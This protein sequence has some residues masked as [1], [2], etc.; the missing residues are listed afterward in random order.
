MSRISQRRLTRMVVTMRVRLASESVILLDLSLLPSVMLSP[1]L[2]FQIPI[3][4]RHS[5][6]EAA[7]S[8]SQHFKSAFTLRGPFYTRNGRKSLQS[9][10]WKLLNVGKRNNGRVSV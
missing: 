3:Y 7:G 1:L 6:S 4:T 5:T 8:P 10:Q 9:S 2:E